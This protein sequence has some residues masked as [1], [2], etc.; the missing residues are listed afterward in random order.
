MTRRIP[1]KYRIFP[2]KIFNL[3]NKQPVIC[4]E[5]RKKHQLRGVR[6]CRSADPV[7]NAAARR[8]M[9][10]LNHI[11]APW[12]GARKHVRPSDHLKNPTWGQGPELLFPAYILPETAPG[13]HAFFLPSVFLFPCS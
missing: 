1:D 3:F 9:C 7:M 12:A 11:S 5:S 6:F 13:K 10:P 2:L 4:C 8:F